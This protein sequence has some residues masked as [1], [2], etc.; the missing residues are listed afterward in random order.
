MLR[1]VSPLRF[2]GRSLDSALADFR[3]A[4]FR[5]CLRKIG[6]PGSNPESLLRARVCL[7]L[8]ESAAA[9][10]SL[11][12]LVGSSD[13]ERAEIA[14][15][16]AVASSRLG[17]DTS[18]TLLEAM[19]Y[20]ISA[21]NVAVEAET[22]YYTALI[23]LAE[24]RL[25]DARDACRRGLEVTNETEI[26]S[27]VK[28]VIPVEHVVA[29]LRELLGVLDSAHGRYRDQLAHAKLA[30]SALDACDVR[31][32]FQE[33]FALKNLTILSRDLDLGEDVAELA[34]RAK[35]LAWTDE[36][37]TVH[38]RTVEALGWCFA[39]R[40]DVVESLRLFRTAASAATSLPEKVILGVDRALI[41]RS[42]GHQPMV[43]EEL[44]HASELAFECNW[45][46]ADGDLRVGL[47]SLAQMAASV[48]PN[49]ARKALDRYRK[50]THATDATFSSRLEDVYRAEEAYTCGVVMRAEGRIA[51]SIERLTFAFST[52]QRA[53]FEWRAA[54]AALEL[55][56]L[57]AGETFRQAVRRDL[58][59]RPD[60]IF[61]ARAHAIAV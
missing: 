29:R 39:L 9:F 52:W 32:V 7:R 44:E 34:T 53:G 14:L 51:A 30:L 3:S 55:A 56:E 24:D 38:F 47:L 26:K 28:Y 20:S 48:A 10:E 35:T 42:F 59:S 58:I 2:V 54:R 17:L 27:S 61:S 41:A 46:V 13:L 22:H 50:I 4:E 36:I 6:R 60:S 21:A 49:L 33:A 45:D 43:I 23:A 8:K 37:S 1:S 15:L 11:E 19:A 57:D 16:R 40:G 31:D 5:S 18:S 12:G 25:A